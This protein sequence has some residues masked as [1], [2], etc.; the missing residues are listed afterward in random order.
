[1]P[2]KDGFVDGAIALLDVLGIKGIWKREPVEEIVKKWVSIVSDFTDIEKAL[3]ND[4]NAK[5]ETHLQFFSD[6]VIVTYEGKDPIDLLAYMSLHL[7]YP[8]CHSFLQKIFLRGTICTGKFRRTENM[9]IGPTIDE[10][11]EYYEQYNWMGITLSPTASVLIDETE[12]KHAAHGWYEKYKIPSKSGSDEEVW[13]LNWPSQMRGVMKFIPDTSEPKDA[14]LK[15]MSDETSDQ[16]VLLKRKITT[17][18][19]D[20]MISRRGE[21]TLHSSRI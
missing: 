16:K 4:Q 21:N 6:T 12:K 3:K 20:E 18:F 17:E 14:L 2:D 11:A 5:I 10:A 8:F 1:M 7:T 19:F 13:A 9:I 15:A